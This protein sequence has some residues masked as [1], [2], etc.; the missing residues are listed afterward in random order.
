[1]NARAYIDRA[2]RRHWFACPCG[3][4]AVGRELAWPAWSFKVRLTRYCS[5]GECGQSVHVRNVGHSYTV[6]LGPYP[7]QTPVCTYHT[8]EKIAS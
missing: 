2:K 7:A 8:L 6:L 5:A 4:R 1:V 3:R